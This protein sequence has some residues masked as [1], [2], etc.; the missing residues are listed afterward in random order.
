MQVRCVRVTPLFVFWVY[1][2]RLPRRD[3]ND[4]PVNLTSDIDADFQSAT[5]IPVISQKHSD[6]GKIRNDAHAQ[7]DVSTSS[8]R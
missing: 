6:L 4:L 1:L 7:R 3:R 2:T 5:G 8:K